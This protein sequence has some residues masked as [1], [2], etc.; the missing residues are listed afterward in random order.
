[1]GEPTVETIDACLGE[2]AVRYHNPWR[3]FGI[4]SIPIITSLTRVTSERTSR[5]PGALHATVL[6]NMT[7]TPILCHTFTLSLALLNGVFQA[8]T[9]PS[10]Y[11][12]R[13]LHDHPC[14]LPPQARKARNAAQ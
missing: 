5:L 1:M 12:D 7:I 11:E 9:V 14:S 13:W 3:W 8:A 2:D 10:H 6:P 4:C